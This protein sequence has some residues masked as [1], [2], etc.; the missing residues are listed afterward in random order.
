MK[1]INITPGGGAGGHWVGTKIGKNGKFVR[2]G[3]H[4]KLPIENNTGFGLSKNISPVTLQERFGVPPFSI[5]DAR[6]GYWQRRK[7]Q[8]LKLGIQS[9]LGRGGG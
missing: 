8:W 1:K 4:M 5:L 9:E 7:R 3:V 2:G 6:Q